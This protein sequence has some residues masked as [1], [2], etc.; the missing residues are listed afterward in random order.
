[1]YDE[2]GREET[3]T[4]KKASSL[5]STQATKKKWGGR[6]VHIKAHDT[7]THLI[8]TTFHSNPRGHP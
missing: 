8:F 5:P 6:E 4:E 3:Q 1:V 2:K 7:H